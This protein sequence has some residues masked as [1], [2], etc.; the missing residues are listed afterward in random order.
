VQRGSAPD[1][2]SSQSSSA[3]SR[4]LPIEGLRGYLALWVLL[5]HVLWV[6]GYQP[7]VESLLRL[8]GA[9]GYA[10]KLFIILSGFVITYL[11]DKRDET[12]LQFVVRRFFRLFPVFIVLFVVA[13]P[14]SHVSLWNVTHASQYL[15][16]ELIESGDGSGIA[17]VESWWSNIQWNIPL[18]FLMFNGAVPDILVKDAPGAFLVPAWTVSLEWQFYLVAPL[19]FA[20]VISAKPYRRLG[21][22]ALC[23]VVFWARHYVIPTVEYGAAL[24]FQVEFFFLGAASYF[25]Y[26]GQ[27]SHR[28]SDTA[29]PIACCLAVFLLWLSSRAWPLIPVVLWMAFFGLL[30]EQP[31]S[32]SSRLVA[33][34]FTNP[35]MLYLGRISYSLYLSHILVIIVIQY[36][37]LTWMPHLSRVVHCGLLLAGT[38]V[39]T[40]AVSAGLYRYLEAPG[41]RVGRTWAHRFDA[42][43]HTGEQEANAY[44]RGTS[45]G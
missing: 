8:M 39:V 18:H 33:P 21:L 12:Y 32:L 36:A 35:L 41:I 22:C 37:L 9:G 42:R 11:L 2:S 23:A 45:W 17:K 26:K 28:Q 29:F 6:S 31:S 1:R 20:W 7:A 14:L 38:T 34:L 10:V 16:S 27:A 4:L 43:R 3:V 15:T 13:I 40:V 30:L 44:S 19:A 5:A 24:P 25:F